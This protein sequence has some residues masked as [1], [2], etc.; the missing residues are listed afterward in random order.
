MRLIVER[1][2]LLKPLQM[3]MGVV[4][5]KQILPILSNVLLETKGDKISLTGTDLEVELVGHLQFNNP[6]NSQGRLTLPGRKLMDIFK[7]LPE[8]SSVE[9]HEEKGRT[10]ILS[11]RSRFTLSTLPAEDFPNVDHFES[12][13]QFNIK[14]SLLH[15]LIQ[16]CAFS[17]AQQDVRYYLNGLLLEITSDYLRVVATDGHRLAAATLPHTMSTEKKTQIIIPRKGVIELLRLINNQNND[18]ISIEIS[19]N[20]IQAVANSYKITSKLIEGRFPEYDR[21]IPK[22]TDKEITVEKSYFKDA[23]NRV[24][25]LC[26]E[27]FR[28]VRF[29]FRQ[30]LLR[31]LA[32]NPEQEAAEEELKIDYDFEPLDIG[33]NVA[34]LIEIINALQGDTVTLKFSNTNNSLVI[35]EVIDNITSVYVVMPMRI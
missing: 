9:L 19:K 10:I 31:I 16:H 21:V 30:N 17:M 5:R 18:L 8:N 29:E 12:D 1:E 4:E 6:S 27:K 3:I 25:I 15:S 24:A 23:L 2:E 35:D 28:G 11:G 33:F 22:K 34:Y 20:N 13:T 14:Q 26:N 32:N 7:A